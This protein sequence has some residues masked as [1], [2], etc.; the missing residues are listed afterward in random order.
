MLRTKSPLNPPE[1]ERGADPQ[2]R[3]GNV[4]SL[5]TSIIADSRSPQG[6]TPS[7]ASEGRGSEGGRGA[8]DEFRRSEGEGG[9]YNGSGSRV[10]VRGFMQMALSLGRRELL[11]LRGLVQRV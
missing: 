11:D 1:G 6:R 10:L 7:F 9:R 8:G 3:G 2:G 5:T 4:S